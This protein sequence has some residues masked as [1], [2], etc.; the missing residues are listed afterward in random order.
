MYP[1]FTVALQ[2]LATQCIPMYNVEIKTKED[3]LVLQIFLEDVIERAMP[4]F[5]EHKQRMINAVRRK[6]EGR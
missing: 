4:L 6:M 2:N 5:V 1:F 3:E